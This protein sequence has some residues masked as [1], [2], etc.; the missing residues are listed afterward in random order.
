M[1]QA[2]LMHDTLTSN[3]FEIFKIF[4]NCL[5]K[6]EIT[7]LRSDTEEL[8]KSYWLFQAFLVYKRAG[9]SQVELIRNYL[10]SSW[11]IT[12]EFSMK[13]KQQLQWNH[14]YQSNLRRNY[15]EKKRKSCYF[16]IKLI[17]IVII[18]YQKRG[19]EWFSKYQTHFKNTSTKF[20]KF[21]RHSNRVETNQEYR[22]RSFSLCIVATSKRVQKAIR[23]Q[24]TSN[25][26]QSFMS[27]TN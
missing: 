2:N 18:E 1:S 25:I 5:M 13:F 12:S 24:L 3:I 7:S 14:Q 22:R 16:K 11:L 8:T 4:R 27:I 9:S 17:F 20:K 10:N 19:T 23:K 21:L 26:S 15:D 6:V